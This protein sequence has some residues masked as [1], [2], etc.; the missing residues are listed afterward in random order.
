MTQ[1]CD[2]PLFDKIIEIERA[3]RNPHEHEHRI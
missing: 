2:H 3:T 1:P